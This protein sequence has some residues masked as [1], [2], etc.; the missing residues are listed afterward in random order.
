MDWYITFVRV[1]CPSFSFVKV[2]IPAVDGE[3]GVGQSAAGPVESVSISVLS[4]LKPLD[5]F[6][7][8]YTSFDVE[9]NFQSNDT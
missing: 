9:W 8:Y 7:G 1:D 6:D 2:S 5:I 3:V 4:I